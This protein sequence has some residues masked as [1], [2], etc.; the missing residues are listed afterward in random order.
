MS[1]VM[2]QVFP[3]LLVRDGIAR[4]FTLIKKPSVINFSLSCDFRLLN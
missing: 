4:A 2:S 1:S 3:L